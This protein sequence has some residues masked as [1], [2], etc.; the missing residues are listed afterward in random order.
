MVEEKEPLI[1][2][3]LGV[4]PKD[5]ST[6]TVSIT[7]ESYWGPPFP[8]ITIHLEITDGWPIRY[9]IEGPEKQ[10]RQ[11]AHFAKRMWQASHEIHDEAEPCPDCGGRLKW[12]EYGYYDGPDRDDVYQAGCMMPISTDRY[13]CEKCQKFWP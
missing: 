3:A 12:V 9:I 10:V 1:A 2:I 13:Y 11:F 6:T 4:S 5:I 8:D 7:G